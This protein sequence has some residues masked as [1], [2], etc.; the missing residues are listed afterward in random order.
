MRLRVCAALGQ[1]WLM[2]L[3]WALLLNLLI[4]PCESRSIQGSKVLVVID[5]DVSLT[6]YGLYFDDLR[7]KCET[8]SYKWL[9]FVIVGGFELD[10][11]T[12]KQDNISLFE[13]SAPKY[14]HLILFPSK[15]RGT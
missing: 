10:F 5:E 7:R 4:S 9:I 14:H 2:H 13:Y 3:Y 11:K 8:K 15:S 1:G 12:I 6:D